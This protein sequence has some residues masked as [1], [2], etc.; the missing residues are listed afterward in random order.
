MGPNAAIPQ[1]TQQ[2]AILKSVEARFESSLFEIRALV[3]ADVFDSELDAARELNKNGFFRAAGA[4][5][6]VVLEA[7][8]KELAEKGSIKTRRSRIPRLS[9]ITSPLKHWVRWRKRSYKSLMIKSD[10]SIYVQLLPIPS[11]RK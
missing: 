1:L 4:V 11:A 10:L 3:Q 5:S 2:V 7:H 9:L 6:G 8:L